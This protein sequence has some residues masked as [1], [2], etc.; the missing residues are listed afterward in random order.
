MERGNYSGA[1]TT[2]LISAQASPLVV[3]RTVGT[4]GY[5]K[6]LDLIE[7]WMVAGGSAALCGASQ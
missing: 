2:E 3:A 6:M 4:E 1:S 5:L 7:T